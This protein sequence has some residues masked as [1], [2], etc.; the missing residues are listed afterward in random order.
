LYQT[1]GGAHTGVW[2]SSQGQFVELPPSVYQ[3]QVADGLKIARK[4]VAPDLLVVPVSAPT[5]AMQ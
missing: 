1:V 4:Q 5:G 2:D 3:K